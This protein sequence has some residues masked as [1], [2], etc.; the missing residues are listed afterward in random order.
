[1]KS[2]PN[3]FVCGGTSLSF[4]IDVLS[5]VVVTMRCSRMP[6]PVHSLRFSRENLLTGEIKITNGEFRSGAINLSAD[7]L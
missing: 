2:A 1:M 3:L 6:Q 7:N 5:S 4:A